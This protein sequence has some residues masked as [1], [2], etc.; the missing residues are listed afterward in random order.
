MVVSRYRS[1]RYLTPPDILYNSQVRPKMK[2]CCHI[3]SPVPI[4]SKIVSASLWVKNHIPLYRP[5]IN[6]ETSQASQF[7]IA[8]SMQSVQMNYIRQFYT[9]RQRPAMPGVVVNLLQSLGILLLKCMFHSSRLFAQ[10]KSIQSIVKIYLP[11][12]SG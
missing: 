1:N 3:C 8:T 5:F 7:V 9:S 4:Q 10:S 12:I 6:E 2:Y 11:H